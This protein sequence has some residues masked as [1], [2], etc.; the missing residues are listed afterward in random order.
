MY[1]HDI[2]NDIHCILSAYAPPGGWCCGGRQG[3]IPPAPPAMTSPGRIITLILLHSC[4]HLGFLLLAKWTRRARL[5]L[6]IAGKLRACHT[7]HTNRSSSTSVIPVSE[8]VPK[9]KTIKQI[10]SRSGG[11]NKENTGIPGIYQDIPGIFNVYA[12]CRPVVTWLKTTAEPAA[13]LFIV[14][15]P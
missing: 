15:L 1:I 5:E 9:T 13:S 11:W 14:S 4:W 7:R 6:K 2:Y 10:A 12:K 8:V 3:P